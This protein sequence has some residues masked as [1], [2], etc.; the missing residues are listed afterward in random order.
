MWGSHSKESLDGGPRHKQ[1][2][3]AEL[4]AFRNSGC[5]RPS[6]AKGLNGVF[7]D[8]SVLTML[9]QSLGLSSRHK[10]VKS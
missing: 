1:V 3:E 7:H 2:T 8:P 4:H 6:Q 9:K 5:S 10:N